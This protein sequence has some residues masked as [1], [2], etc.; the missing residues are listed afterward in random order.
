MMKKGLILAFGIIMLGNF[1]T[2]IKAQNV[3]EKPAVYPSSEK[4]KFSIS[5]KTEYDVKEPVVITF[6]WENK[7][8]KTEKIMIKEYWGHPFGI[9]VSI[10][11]ADNE[12]LTKYASTHF[13]SSQ[14]YFADEL[15]QY[16]IKLKPNEVKEYS[17]SLLSVPVFKK[18]A[19]KENGLP[20][21]KYK[22]RAFYYEQQ[23]NEVEIAIKTRNE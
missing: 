10:K 22:I 19:Y 7:S 14:L 15:K 23:S 3:I 1:Y 6:M 9:G 20:E 17:T 11:N 5:M 18:S 13:L 4:V 21:G 8:D 16:E 12:E 2:E